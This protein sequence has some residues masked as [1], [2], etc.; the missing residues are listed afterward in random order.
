MYKRDLIC[1]CVVS[2]NGSYM[3][4][5][6]RHSCKKLVGKH[7]IF[8]CPRLNRRKLKDVER[9]E[10]KIPDPYFISDPTRQWEVVHKTFFTLLGFPNK[11]NPIGVH[12]SDALNISIYLVWAHNQQR[13]GFFGELKKVINSTFPHL[14]YDHK[15]CGA[16]RK[17]RYSVDN[18]LTQD[19]G[20][21]SD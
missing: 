8:M 18:Q 14:F 17:S 12:M 20:N 5:K 11:D 6:I 4:A 7:S 2:N 1:V 10:L 16:W 19:N 3:K 21:K 13:G 15:S 9:I